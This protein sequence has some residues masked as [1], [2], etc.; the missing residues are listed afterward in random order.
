PVV[1]PRDCLF[2]AVCLFRLLAVGGNRQRKGRVPHVLRAEP[3][4]ENQ[5]A[6]G[7]SFSF[8]LMAPI[9]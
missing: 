3:A 6:G 9:T 8:L 1:H 5:V 7:S 2:P 4:A